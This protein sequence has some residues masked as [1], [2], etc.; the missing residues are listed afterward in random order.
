MAAVEAEAAAGVVDVA[1]AV[2]AVAEE[3]LPR[4]TQRP[5]VAAVGKSAAW[6]W[7]DQDRVS[8]FSSMGR[9]HQFHVT[10][11][12]MGQDTII[13]LKFRVGAMVLELEL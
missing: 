1:V 4:V 5:W 2:E 10:S 3:A 6:V 8:P 9:M 7:G 11:F 13:E 12:S